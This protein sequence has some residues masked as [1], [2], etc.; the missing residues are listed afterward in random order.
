M[1]N[2]FLCFIEQEKQKEY[3]KKLLKK[4]E[5]ESKTHNVFPQKENWFRCLKYFE[6]EEIKLIIIGQDP[7]F[8]K[9]QADGLA[10]S[11][12]LNVCPRSLNNIFKELK[13]DYEDIKIET[14]SLEQWARQGVL[15]INATL[16]VNENAAGSHRNFGWE[17]FLDNLLN[18][19][20]KNNPKVITG[21]WGNEAH[22]IMEPI[23]KKYNLK[24]NERYIKTSH[25]SPLSYS[26]TNRSFKDSK[27]FKRV[28][29]LLD[30]P[31]DFNLRKE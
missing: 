31:I 12:E 7:Y 23:I 9:G 8:L 24:E 26:R 2:K 19:I 10:F 29:N 28:N 16:T 13:K 11:T 18:F 27:F 20:F 4:I 1:K 6:P 30:K 14:Y 3:F 25:P 21:I 5:N 17:I 22:E 15:L